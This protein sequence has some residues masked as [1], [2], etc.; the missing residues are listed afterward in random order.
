[1]KRR[2][3][4]K[5]LAVSGAGAA[6][7]FNSIPVKALGFNSVLSK[8][9]NPFIETDKVLVVIQLL[10]GNDGLN[11]VIPYQD[12]MYYTRRPV[13]AIP[14]SSVL[15]LPNTA[16]GLHPALTDM[17]NLFVDSKIAI[18]QNV[19]YASPNFSHFRA[20]D[21]WH[22]ASNSNQ[23]F[24]TGWLGRYLREEYPNYPNTIPPDPMAIQ[25]G[26]SAS[27][28]L[29]SQVGDMSL[30][31]Q[32]PNQF[33]QLVQG[34]NY[35]GYEKVKTLAGPELDFARRV[36]ADSLQYAT[37]VRDASNN[38][39]NLATYPTNNSLA[40]QLKIVARLIDGGLE[41]RLYV[42]TITGFDTHTQQLIPHN[43]LLTRVNGAINAF[44]TDLFLNNISGRVVG[45]TLSEFGRRVLENGSAGT[46]HGTA[47]PMILFGD[48]V[49]GGI[50]GNNPDLVNLTNGNL[51]YQYDY[52]QIYASALQQLFAASNQELLNVLYQNF[53]TLPLIVPQQAKIKQGRQTFSLGQNYP[54]PF[55]PSTEISYT[56]LKDSHV[57]IRI[58]DVSGREV[59]TIVNEFQSAGTHK[60][61][62]DVSGRRNLS[63]GV[64][65]Y[66]LQAGDFIDV[67]KMILVK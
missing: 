61:V 54:N 58:F 48:L 14:Q 36:A 19:G 28:S 34:P 64:Y 12:S 62:F 21:I 25:I 51:S 8:V 23:Y 7:S 41:T 43:T 16:M 1:M 66:K 32:D 47:A 15:S 37:K 4:I 3:F 53:Q 29:M 56:L 17:K 52:R 20:T 42:V 67:K 49:N 11:T 63:S 10:G 6:L 22:T 27:L 65:F 33:Y 38:G 35:N 60:V 31:F 30:T 45:L 59:Q 50:Y 2:D 13:L 5:T 57:A 18:V 39:Q 9:L 44:Y 40:D 46:D 55:N 26:L 24:T